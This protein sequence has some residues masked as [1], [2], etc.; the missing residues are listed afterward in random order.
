MTGGWSCGSSPDRQGGGDA[1]GFEAEG[2]DVGEESLRRA[3]VVESAGGEVV[4]SEP[5]YGVFGVVADAGVAAEDGAEV[6]HVDVAVIRF[7]PAVEDGEGRVDLAGAGRVS[8]AGGEGHNLGLDG[9]LLAY[10]AQDGL[11]GI[12]V[13]VDVA[14]GGEPGADLAVPVEGDASLVDNKA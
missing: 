14:A 12:L 11:Y 10:L 4:W 2:L 7:G 9:E 1:D 6:N 13:G 8:E 5:D 3:V